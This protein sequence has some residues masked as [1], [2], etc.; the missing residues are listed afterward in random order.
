VA[1]PGLMTGTSH[2]S[3]ATIIAAKSR[4]AIPWCTHEPTAL[5]EAKIV[6]R[7]VAVP[8]QADTT[9]CLALRAALRAFKNASCILYRTKGFSSSPP[10]P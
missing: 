6:S 4:R 3:L 2:L 10:H 8:V 5:N 7:I 1:N 9:T